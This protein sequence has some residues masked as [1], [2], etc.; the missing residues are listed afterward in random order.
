MA[1][2]PS[3]SPNRWIDRSVGAALGA[4]VAAVVLWPEDPAPTTNQPT[5]IAESPSDLAAKPESDEITVAVEPA[6]PALAATSTGN[7]ESSTTDGG[8]GEP[9]TDSTGEDAPPTDDDGTQGDA[10][11]IPITPLPGS[12]FLR[13]SA[14]FDEDKD[15]WVIIQTVRVHAPAYQVQGYYEKALEDLGIRVRSV[16]EPPNDRYK[17]RATITGRARGNVV[18]ISVR[19]EAAQMRTTA[20]IIWRVDRGKR[21][22]G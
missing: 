5:Q 8:T 11:E 9:A 10:P 14:E 12:K 13:R 18:Q 22:T 2:A 3:P 7:A 17:H 6:A 1:D 20:R 4:F 15:A 21:V 16:Q 19:Q